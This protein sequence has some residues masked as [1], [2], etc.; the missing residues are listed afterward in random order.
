MSTLKLESLIA[1][2]VETKTEKGETFAVVSS[3]KKHFKNLDLNKADVLD[4]EDEKG[5]KTSVVRIKDIRL[6]EVESKK[7][8]EVVV[9]D[10]EVVAAENPLD[11]K[12]NEL[13][14]QGN[15]ST[16]RNDL[17]SALKKDDASKEVAIERYEKWLEGKAKKK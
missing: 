14:A 10:A 11:V 13:I 15:E 16:Y 17:I 3:L 5:K 7:A 12:I 6:K 2:G 4:I 8:E 1:Q 9:K